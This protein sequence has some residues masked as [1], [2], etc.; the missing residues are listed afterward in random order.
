MTSDST[1]RRLGAALLGLLQGHVALLGLELQ[2]QRDQALRA[3]LLAGLCLSFALLLLIGISALLLI[4]YWDSHR[5]VVAIGL[6]LFYGL[7][8]LASGASLVLGLKR[9]E[10]PFSASVEELKRDREQLLP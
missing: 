8:L 6:C 3:L 5:L 10:T 2:E 4:L 9:A 7:A 1:P